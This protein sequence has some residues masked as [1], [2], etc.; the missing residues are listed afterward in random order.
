MPYRSKKQRAFMH[1]HHP[2]LASRWDKR[3]G[4]KIVKKRKR[5]K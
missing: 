1:I 2:K 3:Y 5:K 4:G